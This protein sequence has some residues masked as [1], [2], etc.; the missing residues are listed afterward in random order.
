MDPEPVMKAFKKQR[1]TTPPEQTS[2]SVDNWHGLERLFRAAVTNRD[3]AASKKLSHT[4]HHFQVRNELV[5]YE[6][7]GL[8][9]ALVDKKK[10]K[11]KGKVLPLQTNEEYW[12]GAAFYSPRK[13]NDARR[14]QRQMEQEEEEKR[15]QK[16]TNKQL[17]EAQ[18]LIKQQQA[19]ERK[20][21]RAAKAERLRVKKAE[22]A[23]ERERKQ[24][25]N[26]SKKPVKQ[27]QSG[28]RKAS[29]AL[30][31]KAK[32]VRQFGDKVSGNRWVEAPSAAQPSVSKRGRTTK[33][34]RIFE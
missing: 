9:E 13:F 29:A 28:K 20:A 3:T 10:H 25:E 14:R 33:P 18:K 4:L 30:A 8:R 32:R 7:K 16:A 12:G 26:N 17:K 2:A 34:R 11:K 23:A 22:K 15:L 5:E 31:P 24:Q 6:N 19:A 1:P 27:P 21:E